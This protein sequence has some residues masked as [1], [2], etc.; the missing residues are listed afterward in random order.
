M[1]SGSLSSESVAPIT[2]QPSYV[3][4]TADNPGDVFDVLASRFNVLFV[5]LRQMKITVTV[6]GV[7]SNY[8]LFVRNQPSLCRTYLTRMTMKNFAVIVVSLSSLKF[9]DKVLH[10]AILSFDLSD[11]EDVLRV[12]KD[13]NCKANSIRCTFCYADPFVITSFKMYCLSLF[14]CIL[15]SLSSPTIRCFQVA[16]F[17]DICIHL[18]FLIL[19]R[20]LL[21]ITL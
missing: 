21:Y 13:V 7:N 1:S 12:A 3:P 20:F 10:L 19:Q 17:L 8:D 16:T 2:L 11:K 14:G 5:E 18:F 9:S 6:D 15:W 4:G